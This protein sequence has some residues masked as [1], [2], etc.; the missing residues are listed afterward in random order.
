VRKTCHV[1]V[2]QTGCA[3]A[4]QDG[5]EQTIPV[6]QAA[7]G[8]R[9]AIEIAAVAQDAVHFADCLGTWIQWLAMVA[10]DQARSSPL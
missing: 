8:G 10:I 9:D 6:L 7:I 5:L 3:V 2:P 4:H 1:T